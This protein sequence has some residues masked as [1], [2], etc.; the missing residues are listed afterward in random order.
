MT[1][2]G[3]YIYLRYLKEA[4]F[5]LLDWVDD[6]VWT[7]ERV[8]YGASC[9]EQ[10]ARRLRVP[11]GSGGGTLNSTARL[12]SLGSASVGSSSTYLEM[13]EGTSGASGTSSGTNRLLNI[14]H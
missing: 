14:L 13:N 3:H 5:T 4:H 6:H 2:F 8:R 9:L 7:E 10:A 11:R 12:L 1:W